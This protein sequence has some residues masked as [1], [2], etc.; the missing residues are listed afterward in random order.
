MSVSCDQII[1][2]YKVVFC[3]ICKRELEDEISAHESCET[4]Y[5]MLVK[6]NRCIKCGGEVKGKMTTHYECL[7]MPYIG[8]GKPDMVTAVVLYKGGMV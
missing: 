8:Y 4:R 7:G 3:D 5:D 6:Q 2:D 1:A